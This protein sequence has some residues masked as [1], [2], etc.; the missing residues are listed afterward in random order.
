MPVNNRLLIALYIIVGLILAAYAAYA[1]EPIVSDTHFTA[2]PGYLQKSD[3]PNSLDLLSGPPAADSAAFARDEAA[4]K[5]TLHLRNTARW[6]QAAKDA[7]LTFPAPACAAETAAL[8]L[9]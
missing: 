2:A 9:M 8:A 4:R 3:L 7:D 6:Q 5:S 1:T